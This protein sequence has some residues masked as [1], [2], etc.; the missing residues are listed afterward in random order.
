MKGKWLWAV[1][2]GL[3]LWWLWS[4]KASGNGNGDGVTK[5]HVGDYLQSI[6]Y[7]E[8]SIFQITGFGAWAD[9]T[10]YYIA[11]VITAGIPNPL[12]VGSTIRLVMTTTDVGYIKVTYP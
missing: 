2:A 12:T 9:G 1:V 8:S 4:K 3:G 7:P 5:F 10:K 11:K 6:T